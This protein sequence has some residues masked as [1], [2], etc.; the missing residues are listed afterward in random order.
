MDTKRIYNT[1]QK[2]EILKCI[3]GFGEEHFTA[4]DVVARLNADGISV[5]QATVYRFI[6]RLASLGKL[7]KYVV[8]GTTAA[9]YQVIND[10]HGESCREHFHLKCEVCGRLIHVECE[11]L[12][13]IAE[14]I[15]GEHGFAID[16]SK[17]VFY[18]VCRDCKT[19]E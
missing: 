1:K 16:S 8:D 5:G 18:G 13:R 10:G 14:H 6:D 2:D 15:R 9:C 4:A 3:S 11:E 17:T 12:R 7:R 19:D